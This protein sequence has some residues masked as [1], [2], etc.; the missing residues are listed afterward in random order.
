[1]G[2]ALTGPAST[3]PASTVVLVG[4]N[5]VGTTGVT[6]DGWVSVAGGRITGTG[7]G[8]LPE[9]RVERLRGWLLP[10]FIDIHVHGGGGYG[11]SGS[12]DSLIAA[13]EFH[14][15]HGTTRTLISFSSS[16]ESALLER[17]AWVADMVG[18]VTAPNETADNR[19]VL[20]AHLEGPFLSPERRGAHNLDYLL[21]P[22]REVFERFAIA[23]KGTLRVVTVAPELPGALEVIGDIVAAGA[24]AAIGHTD[25]TYDE[26]CAGFDAGAT[27]ATHL[28]NGMR[29][30]QHREPGAP[31]AA[32]SRRVA[33]E[34][35]NDGVHLHPSVT[36]IVAE[37]PDRFVLITDA[38]HAGG[39]GDGKHF[40]EGR[41]LEVLHGQ[42]KLAGTDVLAGS[43]L[44]MDVA[45]QRAVKVCGIPV[46][47]ASAAASANPARVLG[48]EAD[49]G[50]I[51]VGRVADLVL[52]DDEFNVTRVMVAGEWSP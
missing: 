42:V 37:V 35:I 18:A 40:V 48:I 5:V 22:D 17:L 32:L 49:Y 50:S 28:F 20:G 25:A 15:R 43:A 33:C 24:V 29:P 47:A 2:V 11:F 16:P 4:A 14:R 9:G 27:L 38:V 23:S 1:M 3:G 7:K 6:E 41:Q 13:V 12:P 34:V 36:R 19:T 10:G 21:A 44:T 31:G 46:A 39:L 51:S 30:M 52:M 45:V 8:R 26:A